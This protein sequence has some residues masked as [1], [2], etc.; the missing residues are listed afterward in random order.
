MRE[1][2]K[3]DGKTYWGYV[4]IYVDDILYTSHKTDITMKSLEILHELKKDL[5]IKRKYDTYSIYLEPN[6]KNINFYT[7]ETI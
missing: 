1:T 6:I 7:L 2:F 3:D 5:S 4:L